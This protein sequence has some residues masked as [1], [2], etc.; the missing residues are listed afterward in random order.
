[1]RTNTEEKP[2]SSRERQRKKKR[3]VGGRKKVEGIQNE[4]DR[5]EKDEGRKMQRSKYRRAEI[6]KMKTTE[7]KKDRWAE[8]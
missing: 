6:Q 2:I 7:E 8:N 5:K 1:M 4:K 3:G